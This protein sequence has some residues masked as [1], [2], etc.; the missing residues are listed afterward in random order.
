MTAKASDLNTILMRSTFKL[1]G[2]GSVG[3]AFIIGRPMVKEPGKAYFVM[4]TAAHVLEQMKGTHGT[5]FVRTE[6]DGNYEKIPYPVEIR[7]E[8][9]PL[10]TRHPDE[11]AD[12]AAMYV[13]LPRDIDIALLLTNSLAD[14]EALAKFEIHPG[15]ELLCLGYPFGAEANEA[16]FPILRSGKIASFPLIPTKQRK[17]FLYDFQIFPG[18]SG[19][20]VYFVE[21]GRTYYGTMHVGTI[22]FIA[23]IVSQEHLITEKTQSLYEVKETKHPLA[24]AKVVHASFIKETIELLPSLD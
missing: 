11:A 14:D 12:V 18:N 1:V 3:T 24:L 4:V 9:K 7:R 22:Q 5:L 19:G 10:W 23:G 17:T 15:D 20:P 16:G 21:S 8:N 2:N 13:T 6:S